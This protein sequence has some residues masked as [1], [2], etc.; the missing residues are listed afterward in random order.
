MRSRQPRDQAS[1]DLDQTTAAARNV[2]ACSVEKR[3]TV[4][5]PDEHR[6]PRHS[7][8][9]VA[10]G[11]PFTSFTVDDIDH[12]F[13]R[14]GAHG[15]RFHAVAHPNGAGRHRSTLTTPAAT[16]SRLRRLPQSTDLPS[17]PCSPCSTCSPSSP[18]PSPTRTGSDTCNRSVQW[19]PSRSSRTRA[20]STTRRSAAS[21]ATGKESFSPFPSHAEP[22][23]ETMTTSATTNTLRGINW[24]EG[25]E[26]EPT[27]TA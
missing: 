10:D 9:T 12:E 22:G 1:L 3:R 16:S 5:A 11:M 7:S 25:R 2:A 23:L 6:L 8:G 18:P 14:L 4:L 21:R 24:A 15:V 17:A 20:T 27:S 19:T 26:G 13:E